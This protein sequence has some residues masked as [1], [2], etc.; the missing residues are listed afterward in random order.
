MVVEHSSLDDGEGTD[1]VAIAANNV[2][3]VQSCSWSV[4]GEYVTTLVIYPGERW[5]ETAI[6]DHGATAVQVVGADS[7]YRYV[8]GDGNP[9]LSAFSGVNW[10][11][12]ETDNSGF[13]AEELASVAIKR[14]NQS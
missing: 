12:V 10:L 3:D 2:S 13:D 6:N 11:T 7:A 14:L 4:S 5:A 1:A 8:D 9:K